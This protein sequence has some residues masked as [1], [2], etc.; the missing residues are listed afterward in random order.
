MRGYARNLFLQPDNVDNLLASRDE[1]TEGRIHGAE[2]EVGAVEVSLTCSETRNLVDV[3]RK[4][5]FNLWLY[6][7]GLLRLG[8]FVRADVNLVTHLPNAVGK[9]GA[10]LLGAGGKW[11]LLRAGARRGA[12]PV[13]HLPGL[14]RGLSREYFRE[15]YT[16]GDW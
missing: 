5:L 11:R 14:A 8:F 2:K 4:L 1:V 15:G 7:L 16:D 6:T 12:K 9:D 3:E 10:L 13:A